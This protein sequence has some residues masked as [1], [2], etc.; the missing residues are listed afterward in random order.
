VVDATV[1]A[2]GV[3]TVRAEVVAVRMPDAMRREQKS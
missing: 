1:I 3:V 2:D